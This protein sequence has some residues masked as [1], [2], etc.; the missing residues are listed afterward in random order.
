MRLRLHLRPTTRARFLAVPVTLLLGLA[1]ALPAAEAP[2]PRHGTKLVIVNDDGFSAFFSGRYKN[3]DD[4]RHQ[5]ASYADTSVAVFEWCIT[6]GSRVNFPTPAAELISTGV[7]DFGRRGD[8]LA[9]ETLRRLAAAGTDTLAVVAQACRANG[10]LCYASMRMNGDYAA[11]PKDDSLTR[12]FNSDFWRA[13]PEFRVRGPKGEDRTKLSYAYPEVRAFKLALLRDAATRAIDGI[14]LDF[15]RHPPFFG[16]EEPMVA[17]FREKHGVDPR[18]LPATDPRWGPVRAEF[19]TAFL[20]DTRQLLDAAGA[21]HGRRLGLSARIDHREYAVLGC[22]LATWLKEGLLDYLVVGQRTLGG[23]EFDLAPFVQLA[24]EAG[25][26]CAVLF[27]EEGIVSGHD[28]TAAEDKL[29]KAGKMA[30]PQRDSLSLAQYQQRATRWYAAGADGIHLF[31]ENNR[32]VMRSL[33]TA[34]APPPAPR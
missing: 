27:G 29:I 14:N 4:L 28:L 15:L 25:T 23:Y 2:P 21:K 6:S 22:D 3:A 7:T 34:T 30:A 19:M 9:A 33:G 12:Q 11:S 32:A 18:P 13:H 31:N 17:A 24:R 8:Q 26:G 16:F 10:L 1:A 5:V 20:R